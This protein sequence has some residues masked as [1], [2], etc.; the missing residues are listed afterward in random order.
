[1]VLKNI[2]E[3]GINI[4]PQNINKIKAFFNPK[5]WDKYPIN[6]G[7]MNIPTME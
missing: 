4:N 6:G 5:L 3:I 1:M 7:P 2:F